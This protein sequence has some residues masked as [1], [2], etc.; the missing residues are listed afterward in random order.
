MGL[1][2]ITI[3]GTAL[4]TLLALEAKSWMPYLSA[5][6]VRST[7]DGMPPE[8]DG[9]MRS[10][11]REEI[12]GDLSSYLER[13][14]AGLLFALRLRR[15]GGRRLAAELMLSHVLGEEQGRSLAD[16]MVGARRIIVRFDSEKEI[17]TYEDDGGRMFHQTHLGK[18]IIMLSPAVNQKLRAGEPVDIFT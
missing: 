13:P 4:G 11:W 14:L 10:R 16:R 15:R 18:N 1:L 2:L 6:L 3:I 12:E 5:R 7:V 8:L 9:E 17:L